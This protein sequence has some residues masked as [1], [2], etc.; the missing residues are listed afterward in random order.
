MA[1]LKERI[2][3]IDRKNDMLTIKRNKLE[4]KLK[5]TK[6]QKQLEYVEDDAINEIA[7]AKSKLDAANNKLT[8]IQLPVKKDVVKHNMLVEQCCE[9]NI[10]PYL[11]GNAKNKEQ[12]FKRKE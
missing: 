2:N 11:I 6:T 9:L 10:D 5:H 1:E 4:V 12:L 3:D 7:V 8:R